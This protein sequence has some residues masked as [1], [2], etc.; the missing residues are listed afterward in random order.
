VEDVL[1]AGY[2]RM[3]PWQKVRMISEL[4][5]ATFDL[6]AAGIRLKHPSATDEDIR[7]I[8]AARRLGRQTVLRA[9]GRRALPGEE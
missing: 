9:T 4:S 5:K 8:L 6:A 1:I 7:V 2:R 3:E